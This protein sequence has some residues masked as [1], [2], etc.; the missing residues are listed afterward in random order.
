MCIAC[1]LRQIG[2][3]NTKRVDVDYLLPIDI[4]NY[5][6]ILK[7]EYEI[8]KNKNKKNDISASVYKFNEKRSL[9]E[10][11]KSYYKNIKNGNI[12]NYL[13]MKIEYYE[14]DNYL[15]QIKNMLD[16]FSKEL[17]LYFKKVGLKDGEY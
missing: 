3:I 1:V 7:Y 12:F 15:V 13:D 8:S 14:D 11:Y 2:M 10:Y 17:E 5:N 9:I 4:Y 6:D 16:R